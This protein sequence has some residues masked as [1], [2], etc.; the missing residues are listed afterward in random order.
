[1]KQPSDK[2]LKA[3][4]ASVN[5]LRLLSEAVHELT[6]VTYGRRI[7]YCCLHYFMQNSEKCNKEI[8]YK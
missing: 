8:S 2:A 6:R 1:M 3:A 4:P 7:S 5:T